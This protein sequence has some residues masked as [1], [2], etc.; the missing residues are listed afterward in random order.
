MTA[1]PR[2]EVGGYRPPQR[3]HSRR[4]RRDWPRRRRCA[5][6]GRVNARRKKSSGLGALLGALVV[7]ALI[8]VAGEIGAR[9]Y[10]GNEIAKGFRESEEAHGAVVEEDPQVS[11]GASPVLLAALT[12]NL[13]S[14]DMKIPSTLAIQDPRGENGRPTVAGTPRSDVTLTNVDITDQR[15]PV[16]GHVEV[17]TDIPVDL[18]LAHANIQ[19][20]DATSGGGFFGDLA[21]QALRLTKLTPHPDRGVLT[22]EFSGGLVTADIRPVVRD[23]GITAE[24]EG[25][26]V[27]G[28]PTDLVRL[29]GEAAV[30][31]PA[32][33]IGAGITV[34]SVEVTDQGTRAHLTGDD[35]RLST[36]A[37]L[38]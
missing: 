2:R 28:L 29:L 20:A 11:F 30:N 14:M 12:K 27:L 1:G 6:L 13:G 37:T 33:Q 19:A 25:G 23:G 7:I 36:I 15:D 4:A 9:M 17:H 34:Q 32:R 26:S 8:I 21:Q 5:T 35:I 3:R 24:V 10:V 31:G 16:A 38:R 22:A 18:M